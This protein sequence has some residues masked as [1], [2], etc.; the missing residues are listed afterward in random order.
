MPRGL[1]EEWERGRTDAKIDIPELIADVIYA[2]EIKAGF[3]E[4]G[5]IHAKE[6]KIGR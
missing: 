4:A 1:T 5:E 6:I 2:K 3:V